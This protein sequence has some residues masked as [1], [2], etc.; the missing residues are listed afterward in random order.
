[1]SPTN[2]KYL[3]TDYQQLSSILYTF[4]GF[5]KFHAILIVWNYYIWVLE[6]PQ[7]FAFSNRA[8][9]LPD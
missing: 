5:Q 7:A 2:R 1:M 9:P 8:V 6:L 3:S 4:K